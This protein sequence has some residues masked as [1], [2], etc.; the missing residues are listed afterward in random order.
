MRKEANFAR[1]AGE[2]AFPAL[3]ES[4]AARAS[5]SVHSA[6]SA[7][8]RPWSERRQPAAWK[9]PWRLWRAAR[10][11]SKEEMRWPAA[12]SRLSSQTLYASDRSTL[13]ALSGRKAGYTRVFSPIF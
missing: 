9:S 7:V 4:N 13:I 1:S 8:S 5:W 10:R 12:P 11:S 6:D 3:A 2:T